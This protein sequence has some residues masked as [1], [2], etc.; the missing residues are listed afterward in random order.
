MDGS[1]AMGPA[2]GGIHAVDNGFDAWF[3]LLTRKRNAHRW[4]VRFDRF[5]VSDRDS[6]PIDDN[7]ESGHAWTAAWRLERNENWSIGFEWRTLR[8]TRPAFGY[9]GT[10]AKQHGNQLNFDLRYR[11]RPGTR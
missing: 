2:I 5:G 9:F 3:A 1:T 4:S 11:L 7:G 10:P 6:T 8:L